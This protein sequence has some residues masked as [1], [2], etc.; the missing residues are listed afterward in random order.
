MWQR[1][2][3]QGR[4]GGVANPYAH[5]AEE[6]GCGRRAE[7]FSFAAAGLLDLGLP[8]RIALLLTR[9]TLGRLEVRACAGWVIVTSPCH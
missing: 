2:E 8:E 5:V 4:T 6:V 1:A 7:M 9:S 3:R